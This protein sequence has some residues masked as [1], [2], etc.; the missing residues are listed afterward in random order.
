MDTATAENIAAE[1]DLDERDVLLRTN[2]TMLPR[3]LYNAQ[4]SLAKRGLLVSAQ[5][6]RL[7]LNADGVACRQALDGGL[8]S[9]QAPAWGIVLL[10]CGQPLWWRPDG[11]GY[12]SDIAFAGLYTPRRARQEHGHG[13]CGP[14]RDQARPPAQ[15]LIAL[16]AEVAKAEERLGRLTALRDR[17][18][19][20]IAAES[21]ST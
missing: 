17:V 19:D 1:L 18:R 14:G 6:H 11:G 10:G 21:S 2:G 8:P 15:M 9:D 4:W 13:R 5:D 16:E 20:A 7:L 12:S 3:K